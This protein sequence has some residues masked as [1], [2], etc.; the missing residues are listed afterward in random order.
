[1]SEM[2]LSRRSIV[3]VLTTKFITTKK[4]IPKTTS[5]SAMAEKPPELGDF[6]GVGHFQAKF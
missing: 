1:M 6:N 2:N 4:N 3:Q 5:S